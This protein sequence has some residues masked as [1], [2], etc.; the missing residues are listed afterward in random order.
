MS[1]VKG[2]S[3]T[4]PNRPE[5][6]VMWPVSF[7]RPLSRPFL[8]Y[9]ASADAV[10]FTDKFVCAGSNACYVDDGNSPA[11]FHVYEGAFRK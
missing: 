7:L 8:H 2:L 10:W 9:T 4:P 11:F 1:G 3:F 5:F 6:E